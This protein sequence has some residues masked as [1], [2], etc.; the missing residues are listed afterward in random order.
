M[1]HQQPQPP[2][3]AAESARQ[4]ERTAALLGRLL[5]A[6]ER[7]GGE[8]SGAESALSA[9][10]VGSALGMFEELRNRIDR[11]ETQLVIEG[12]RRGMDWKAIAGHQG[13]NSSQAAS[14][15]YQRLVTR[16]EEIRQGVR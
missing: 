8:R 10:E 1:D 14:Q 4:V 3:E 6:A 7:S 2:Q 15:R 13:F 12:R 11:L 5:S 9:A 16:L